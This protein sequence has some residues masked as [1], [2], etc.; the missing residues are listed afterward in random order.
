[1]SIFDLFILVTLFSSTII[2]FL[3]L[4]FKL[5]NFDLKIKNEVKIL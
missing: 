2:I 4:Q 5:H 1:M 3:F